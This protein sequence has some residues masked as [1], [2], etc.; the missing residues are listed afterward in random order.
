MRLHSSKA[1]NCRHKRSVDDENNKLDLNMRP[2]LPRSSIFSVLNSS[3]PQNRTPPSYP[4]IQEALNALTAVALT[5][6]HSPPSRFQHG[7]AVTSVAP[8]A[9]WRRGSVAPS[10]TSR[11]QHLP[12]VSSA[13]RSAPSR[14]QPLRMSPL[15]SSASEKAVEKRCPSSSERKQQISS[16]P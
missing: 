8:S 7:D 10:D 15:L 3:L 14:P 11:S 6:T 16:F 13:A 1:P 9:P 4:R 12:A 5:S 2:P